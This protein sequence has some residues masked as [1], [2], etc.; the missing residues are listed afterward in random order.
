[1]QDTGTGGSYPVSTDRM[2]WAVVAWE[3]YQFTGDRDWLKQ[4]YALI[5]PSILQDE[6]VVYDAATG[7]PHGESSFLDWRNQT[8]PGWMEPADIFES[9]CL[10][11][12]AVHYQANVVTA[13]MA[14]ALQ[15]DAAAGFRANAQKIKD[16][17]NR[18]LWL[19]DRGYYGQFLYGR[20][21]KIISPRSEALCVLFGIADS[22]R[23]RRVISSVPQTPF[24]VTCVY[25]QIP[26]VPPYHN[27]AVWPFVQAYWMLAAA[28]TDN[29][30]AV[31][32]SVAAI[33]RAA[34]KRSPRSGNPALHR[35][36]TVNTK[37]SVSQPTA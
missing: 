19:E 17:I 1:M 35:T 13:Q 5:K 6:R 22:G 21:Y 24:G 29:A 33:Y 8:Y 27:D 15:D 28:R 34:A 31:M 20:N 18:S 4:A 10:D 11:T 30:P 3:I 2:I 25:P 16:G 26:G 32:D 12:A 37:S 36:L 23:A 14:E 7:L 9:E